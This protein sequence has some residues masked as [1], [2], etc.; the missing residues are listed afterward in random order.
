MVLGRRP[1]Q[2]HR[3]SPPAPNFSCDRRNVGGVAVVEVAGDLDLSTAPIL[4]RALGAASDSGSA[5]V[6]VDM[7]HLEFM[8]CAGLQAIDSQP[9]HDRL[10]LV[11][12]TGEV[13][14]VLE[15]TDYD[16]T[17]HIYDTLE[18]ATAAATQPSDAS[19]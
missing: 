6:I 9:D 14:R 12:P 5:P 2:G 15:L 18:E 10:H 11:H 19:R 7:R 8:D 4:Q 13:R 1:G 17:L 3:I 16:R